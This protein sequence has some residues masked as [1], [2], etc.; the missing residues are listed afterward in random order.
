MSDTNLTVL[1]MRRRKK[2]VMTCGEGQNNPTVVTSTNSWAKVSN[3]FLPLIH[4]HQTGRMKTWKPESAVP[5]NHFHC[6]PF[7]RFH[8]CSLKITFCSQNLEFVMLLPRRRKILLVASHPHQDEPN[9]M[10]S[11]NFT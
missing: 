8:G 6:H 5:K 2:N 1:I 10:P 7:K 3:T 11:F 9:A 4:Q